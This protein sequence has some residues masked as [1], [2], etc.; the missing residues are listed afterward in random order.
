M[1]VFTLKNN[2]GGQMIFIVFL[3]GILVALA[4]LLPLLA[5]YGV[6]SS[7]LPEGLI[8]YFILIVLGLI[9]IWYGIKYKGIRDY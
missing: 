6:L 2:G 4:G 9:L 3:F 7:I 8:S 5:Q 1:F